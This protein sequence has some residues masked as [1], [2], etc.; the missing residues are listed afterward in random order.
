MTI[1]RGG[2]RPNSGRKTAD[3]P[4]ELTRRQVVLDQATV[5]TLTRLGRGNLSLGIR[6]AARLARP[7]TDQGNTPCPT[8]KGKDEA[9]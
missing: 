2:R 5:D 3:N 4:G 6:E 9:T 8:S 1:Q 7:T